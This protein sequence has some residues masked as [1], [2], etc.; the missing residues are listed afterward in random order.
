MFAA[1]GL[2]TKPVTDKTSQLV[3]TSGQK[4]PSVGLGC[5]KIPNEITADITYQAIKLGYRCIDEA[6]DY[7]NEKECGQGILKA[8]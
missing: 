6:A 7:G 3:L 5:W 4:M 8:L 1:I 2:D